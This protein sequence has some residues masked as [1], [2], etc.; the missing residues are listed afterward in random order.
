MFVQSVVRFTIAASFIWLVD[1]IVFIATYLFVGIA[2]SVFLSRAAG[3][4]T[5]FWLHKRF[6]FGSRS[7]FTHGEA[8]QYAT[9]W[10]LN[11]GL[12]VLGISAWQAG[13]VTHIMIVKVAVD[14]VVFLTNFVLTGLIFRHR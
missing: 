14:I 5:G 4:L 6:T 11:Y 9:L 2:V 13:H 10:A 12:T 3:G 8:V 1:F 7:A